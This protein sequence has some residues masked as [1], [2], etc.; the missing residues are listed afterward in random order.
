MQEAVAIA[1]EVGDLRELAMAVRFLGHVLY[2][3]GEYEAAAASLK[4]SLLLARRLQDHFGI[5]WSLHF[6][7][8]LVL[9]QGD[10]R[11]AQELYQEV[12]LSS[13]N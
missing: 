5:P 7:G 13:G 9:Q 10:S 1:R 11:Q 8:D 6:L 4:E 2:N 3:L 12:L